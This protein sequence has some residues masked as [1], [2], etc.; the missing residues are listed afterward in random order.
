MITIKDFATAVGISQAKARN[1]A[2]QL[3]GTR[4]GKPVA[5]KPSIELPDNAPE[6]YQ[7]MI[8]A[9]KE[10]PEEKPAPEK[11]KRHREPEETPEA[12]KKSSEEGWN[13]DPDSILAQYGLSDAEEPEQEDGQQGSIRTQPP[14]PSEVEG[15]QTMI[16]GLLEVARAKTEKTKGIAYLWSKTLAEYLVDS[17]AGKEY[18]QG[19][20]LVAGGAIL[21]FTAYKEWKRPPGSDN[22]SQRE[23]EN[24]P[25]T[26][27]SSPI[28]W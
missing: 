22:R 20:I 14:D 11:N 15:W 27:D 1:I 26:G 19:I 3:G 4:T 28:K 16:D 8:L 6:R 21:A 24:Q 10:T 13:T 9:Q 2:D 17:G 12:K 7:A 23:R 18:G 5:G 25:D